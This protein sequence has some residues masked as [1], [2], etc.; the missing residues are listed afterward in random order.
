MQCKRA[1]HPEEAERVFDFPLEIGGANLLKAGHD[2]KG[3]HNR[4]ERLPHDVLPLEKS[5]NHLMRL[6]RDPPRSR[7]PKFS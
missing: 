1:A 7:R 5:L 2:A 6:R 4:Y 3:G